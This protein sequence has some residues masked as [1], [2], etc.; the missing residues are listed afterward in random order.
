M[1]YTFQPL[2][3]LAEKLFL[4]MLMDK[5]KLSSSEQSRDDLLALKEKI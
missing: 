2:E 1:P 3:V 5:M 4:P